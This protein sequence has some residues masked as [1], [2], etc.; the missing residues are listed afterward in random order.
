LNKPTKY[1]PRWK[2]PRPYGYPNALDSMGSIASPLLAS[3][4][5]TLIV[6]VL[7]SVSAFRLAEVALL[8]LVVAAVALVGSV[9]CSFQARQYVAT[10]SEIEDW[11][12]DSAN[13]GRRRGLRREQRLYRDRFGAWARR[14]RMAYNIGILSLTAGVTLL[15]VPHGKH[16]AAL[17]IATIAVVALAFIA[18]ALWAIGA[19][20]RRSQSELPAVLPE[21]PTSASELTSEGAS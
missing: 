9:E 4:S 8:L 6:V 5:I 3:V 16:L 10:P 17:R 2:P 14:A 13:P 7:S 11:W 15:L 20:G 18:E 19:L 12:P 21:P 1:E